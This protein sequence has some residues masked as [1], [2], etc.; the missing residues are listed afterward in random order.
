MLWILSNAHVTAIVGLI[1]ITA[2]VCHNKKEEYNRLDECKIT[3]LS[4]ILL[5]RYMYKCSNKMSVFFKNLL[6]FEDK[7]NT[8]KRHV[9]IK[10]VQ[11]CCSSCTNEDFIHNKQKPE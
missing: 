10:Y 9:D 1:E 7:I 2:S 5:V 4:F 11:I 8:F 3:I 6:A